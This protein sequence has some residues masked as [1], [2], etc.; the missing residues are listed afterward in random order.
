MNTQD[1]EKTLEYTVHLEQNKSEDEKP[2]KLQVTKLKKSCE[3]ETKFNPP[4]KLPT[5]SP[6]IKF[7]SISERRPEDAVA[8]INPSINPPIV[9]YPTIPERKTEETVKPNAFRT[10]KEQLVSAHTIITL[11]LMHTGFELDENFTYRLLIKKRKMLVGT[12]TQ[13][14]ML[15]PWAAA[16]SLSVVIVVVCTALS[17]FLLKMQKQMKGKI[18]VPKTRML[19]IVEIMI[20]K[21][22]LVS[23]ILVAC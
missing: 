14:Q 15:P 1:F 10:A 5:V 9:R 2:A 8:K 3:P 11:L 6:Q 4:S 12:V 7:S 13:L 18:M 22:L 20:P 21:K 19:E 16:Q 17:F 23:N